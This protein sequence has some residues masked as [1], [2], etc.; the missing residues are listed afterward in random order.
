MIS[1]DVILSQLKNFKLLKKWACADCINN[2]SCFVETITAF[3][4][5]LWI[6]FYSDATQQKNGF[7]AQYYTERRKFGK[8]SV[9]LRHIIS[10]F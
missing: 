7:K 9:F 5:S 10:I 4:N 1:L 3:A 8:N 2:S 6:K